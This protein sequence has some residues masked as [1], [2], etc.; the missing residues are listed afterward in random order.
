MLKSNRSTILNAG[1]EDTFVR[2]F[3]K[4]DPKDFKMDTLKDLM[5]KTLKIMPRQQEPIKMEIVLRSQGY[6]LFYRHA[7][8]EEI[9]GLMSSNM[10]GHLMEGGL[11]ATRS[12]LMLGGQHTSWRSNDLGLP[13]GVGLSNPGLAHFEVEQE[14]TSI[15]VHADVMLQTTTYMVA[16]NPLG[17]SQGIMKMR[18]SRV[19]LPA[20]ALVGFSASEKTVQLKMDTPTKEEP[21]SVLFS[22]K[23]VAFIYGR[24]PEKAMKYMKESCA[25]C[26]PVALVTRGE[27]YRKSHV[28]RDRDNER[29]GLESHVEVYDCESYTG[30]SSMSKVILDSF[31]PSEIN[32][33]GSIPGF[34]IMGL[35]Q[36]R[37]YFYYYP[38]T[39]TCSMKAVMHKAEENPTEAVLIEAKMNRVPAGPTGMRS[40]KVEGSVTMVGDIERKWN[41]NVAV[42]AD[43]RNVKSTVNVKIARQAVP[44]LSLAPRA[45]CVEVN[46]KWSD[47]PEDALET[48]S[49]IEP[50]V[51][52]DVSFVWGEA[53]ENECPIANTEEVSTLKIKVS[54]TITE[55]QR[56]A[57]E[58]RD[59]YPYS[60]CDEDRMAHGRSGVVVPI[61]EACMA[62]V[63]EY[64]TPRRYAF[65][66]NF[67]NISPLGM[68]AM[69]RADT[70]IKA[71]LAPYWDMHAPHGAT[72]EKKAFN[73][74]NIE[75]MIEF[76]QAGAN[77]HV[78]TAQMHS[79]YENVDILKNLQFG[80]R[81]ARIPASKTTAFKTGLVGI[82]NVAPESV[83]TFDNATL[84]YE[85]PTCFTLVSGDCSAQPRYAVFA[86]KTDKALP[87][88]V[89]IYAGGRNMEFT[90]TNS[91]I[92]VRANGKV[93]TISEEKP[94]VFSNRGGII[95]YFRVT[96]VGPRYFIEVPMLMLSFRYTGD[97]ITNIIPS[98]H[99][100]QHCG[101][102]GNFN[103]QMIDELVGPSGCAMKD[104]SDLA[105]SY[106]LRDQTCQDSIPM[107]A[108]QGNPAGIVDFLDQFSGKKY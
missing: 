60:Q 44:S 31:K 4:L 34:A 43:E 80:L 69:H 107:P 35:M 2:M 70:I 30:K 17:V 79:H 13:V 65:D 45:L 106:I 47:M 7:G 64:A 25:E 76:L 36:M 63:M 92:E 18:G 82:C 108:C 90:P 26:K 67:D 48:P 14:K 75:M 11:K 103:G 81:N 61:T 96:Q 5:Q 101:L 55:E 59:S 85:C 49:A 9:M 97:E 99:R 105:K 46:T 37:N 42:E 40:T 66:I 41:V 78:H 93:V 56:K 58:S 88:A 52:R 68:K 8:M 1:V 62:A 38:P 86:K 33:H 29:L 20:N 54:G 12:M 39:T 98:T 50:S 15:K 28:L 74:G 83:V 3:R 77:I 73:S 72:A 102:C 57:A 53:P 71:G 89:K 22:S 100:A 23:T 10:L 87:L 84:K 6:N 24:E 95:E 21:M 94:F 19:H 51:E 32:S 104:A 91:G 16:F 27:Q